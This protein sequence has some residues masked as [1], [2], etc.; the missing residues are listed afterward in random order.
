MLG[1]GY[2]QPEDVKA[3]ADGA[4]AY[5]TERSGDLLRVTLASANRAAARSSRPGMTAP[6]QI[7]LD[8]PHHAAYVVEY[9]PS[10]RLWKIDLTT[11]A[12]T[13]LL[14]GLEN[15]V[16]LILTADLQIA[17]ISEQAAAGGRVSRFDLATSAQDVV[18]SGLT[19]PFY[20][21]WLDAAQTTAGRRRARPGEPD[22]G[23]QCRGRHVLRWR[24]RACRAPVER[25]RDDARAR[26]S[27]AATASI[28]QVDLVG[29]LPAGRAAADG[30][31]LHAVRQGQRRRPGRHVGRSELLLPGQEVPFGGTLPLMINHL[32]AYNDGAAYYRVKVDGVVHTDPWTDYHWNGFNYVA[33]TTGRR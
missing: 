7:F 32:R 10:G 29:R 17:Y 11:G 22:H 33:Q 31:R 4:H 12:K 27:S 3:S 1:T 20:L 5:V 30:H 26:C 23:D 14:V 19:A 21:T 16:G 25:R 13:A 6:Q 24:R 9:A 18:A 15:A 28:E 8:E 2:S